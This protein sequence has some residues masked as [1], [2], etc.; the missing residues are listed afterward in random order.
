MS[1][2]ALRGRPRL[3]R[4]A[5]SESPWPALLVAFVVMLVVALL[6]GRKPFLYD[7][8]VYWTLDGQFTV[9]GH[10]SL[11]NFSDP[12]R[13][14]APALVYGALRS[15]AGLGIWGPTVV[16]KLFNAALMATI[17][18]VLAPA[19][20]RIA[21]PRVRFGTARR[22]AVAALL[23]VFWRGYLNFPLSDLP[24][25]FG[26]LAAL[27]LVGR[28]TSPFA[29]LG[30]GLLAGVAVDTR[31]AY[32]LIVPAV[33]VL[34]AWRSRRPAGDEPVLRPV[35]VTAVLIGLL[36]VLVPQSLYNHRQDA[37]WTPLPGAG[38]DLSSFQ[39]TTGL[40]L[41]RYETF[42]GTAHGPRLSYVD[43][44]T[45]G[46]VEDL[47]KDGVVNGYGDYAG[48][49]VKHPIELGGV[50]L[51]HAFNG[52]DQRYSTPY[53]EHLDTGQQRPFRIASL[54]VTFLGLLRLCW[55][56]ARRGLGPARWR[57]PVALALTA[58]PSLPSAVETRFLLPIFVLM[59]LLVV[60]PGWPPPRAL[61]GDR[62]ATGARRFATPAAIGAG[63]MAFWIVAL[64]ITGDAT[65][66]LQLLPPAG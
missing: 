31:P 65:S 46:A 22:L 55:P 26:G 41:Q 43:P 62:D 11:T 14:Y 17:G 37:G 7:A 44:H 19:L 60:A 39:L 56:A 27:V 63:A 52:I 42:I 28:S 32:L 50:F 57:Y 18:C 58:L 34:A 45:E 61:L 9:N 4:L 66:N 13:G 36:I 23:L 38:T 20:A 1:A 6:A 54:L 33:L 53:V 10:W 51:R 64:L 48:L 21:W 30:A 49:I 2:A 12:Q 59:S 25:L 29:L 3:S 47:G 24:A 16:V 5:S 35:A 15:F 8:N 40:Q